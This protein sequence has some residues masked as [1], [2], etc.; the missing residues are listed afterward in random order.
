MRSWPPGGEEDEDAVA[1]E[2]PT[3]AR[4]QSARDL[5]TERSRPTCQTTRGRSLR[6]LSHFPPTSPTHR[7]EPWKGG[8]THPS[9]ERPGRRSRT[10][11][12]NTGWLLL[13]GSA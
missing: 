5:M 9:P 3:A 7:D 2:P 6:D 12:V 11:V 4:P 13:T 8:S 10:R 1:A